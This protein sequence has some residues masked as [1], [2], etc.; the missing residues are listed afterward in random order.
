VLVE[1]RVVEQRYDA[2]KEVLD[3]A[4]TVTE[5]AERYGVTRRQVLRGA[6]SGSRL[7]DRSNRR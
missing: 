5:V 3:G 7:G 1:L 4:A 2:V 6:W